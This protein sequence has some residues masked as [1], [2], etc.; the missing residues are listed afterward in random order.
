MVKIV[1][2]LELA[3]KYRYGL[4]SR[5]APL[6][7]FRPY[8]E[9]LPNFI[10]GCSERD[11]SRN[12]IAIVEATVPV[13]A[14]P[15]TNIRGNLL[16]ILGPVGE[17]DAERIALLEHYCPVKPPK[18]IDEPTVQESDRRVIDITTGWITFHV[19][20]PGC[21]DIDDAIAYHPETGG[22]AITIAD[23]ASIVPAG[24]EMDMAA[25]AIGATFYDLEGR[26]IRPMLPP[27]ISEEV[28]SLLPGH[29]RP[30]V[31]L[32]FE[33][34]AAMF[35]RT[36]ITVAHS[37]TYES[38]AT[39]GIA[40]ALNVTGDTHDWIAT[41]M[42]RY[43]KVAAI[44][45][46]GIL[47]VQSAPDAAAISHWAAISPELAHLA[48]EAASYAPAG[49]GSQ[50][51]AGLGLQAYC[52]ASSPLRRY[53]DLVNQRLLIGMQPVA[54]LCD[55]LN[56]RAKANKRWARDL[57]FLEKVTPGRIH[58]IDVRW[59]DQTHVWVPDWSRLI[60][61][62]HEV[63]APPDPGTPDR[64]QIFCDPTRRNWKRRVLTSSIQEAAPLPS[65]AS[66][67]PGNL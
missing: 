42:I 50:G 21:R 11:T 47:R 20:P 53:A 26:V 9:A 36:W 37:F 67:V 28:G 5:G 13:D 51:H 7:L 61:I 6:Y 48:N 27:S 19:D 29:R 3:S 44:A 38:F 40:A 31:T 60:R 59:V 24:S 22:F 34:G 16:R 30:G 8:D 35:Q 41:Q 65:T 33:N 18:I 46:A 10:V 39:S 55:H 49:P 32:F 43:N 17:Y 56:D 23:V 54:D 15:N 45:G 2:V 14:T 58:E 66:T 1:G 52:H 12:C 57:L 4:T 62:R 63:T 64:I 25:R